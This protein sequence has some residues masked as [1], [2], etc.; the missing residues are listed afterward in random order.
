[1]NFI[2]NNF[3]KISISGSLPVGYLIYDKL[4]EKKIHIRGNFK[5]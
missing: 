5:S 1:M 4:K 3:I 2:R